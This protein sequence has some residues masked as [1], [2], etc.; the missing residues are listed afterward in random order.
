MRSHTFRNIAFTLT[1]GAST[2]AHAATAS[3]QSVPATIDACFV[4]ASGTLYRIDTPASPAAGAPKTCLSPIHT[5]FTWNMQGPA[6]LAGAPGAAG[7][8]GPAG[9]SGASGAV[10]PT[11]PAGPS[12]V[13]GPVGP[14][15]PI[16]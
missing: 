2:L 3:A 4:P 11:G 13:A 16:G 10:G 8:V 14:T 1:A 5:K 9:P 7:G 15:G 12:G 6:G